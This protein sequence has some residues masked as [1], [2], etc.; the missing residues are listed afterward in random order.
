M[1]EEQCHYIDSN[2]HDLMTQNSAENSESNMLKISEINFQQNLNVQFDMINE[3]I[4]IS[5]SIQIHQDVNSEMIDQ[6]ITRYSTV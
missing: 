6:I 5:Y 1:K 3:N 2:L 4:S